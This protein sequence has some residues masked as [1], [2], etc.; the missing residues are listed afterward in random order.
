MFCLIRGGW[1]PSGGGQLFRRSPL[2]SRLPPQHL[3]NP[4]H[5]KIK[6]LINKLFRIITPEY[7]PQQENE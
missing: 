1:N 5:R 2:P 6:T 3:L 7:S 4:K